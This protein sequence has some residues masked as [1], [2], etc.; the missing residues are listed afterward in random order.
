MASAP[1]VAD[2]PTAS[3]AFLAEISR[4]RR[5]VRDLEEQLDRLERDMRR[6]VDELRR[7]RLE[8]YR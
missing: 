4:L 8:R 5:E 2:R 6:V 3:D 1:L 7:Y